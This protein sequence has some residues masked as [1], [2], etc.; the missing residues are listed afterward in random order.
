MDSLC[1][2]IRL[3]KGEI[4]GFTDSDCI[5]IK[6]WIHNAVSHFLANPSCKRIAGHIAIFYKNQVPTP[7]ELYNTL[8]SFPQKTHVQKSGTSVTGNLF[9]YKEVFDKVGLFDE[10]QLSLG[11][12]LWGRKAQRAGNTIH[13]VSD[14]RVKHPA[15]DFRQLVIKEKRVGGGKATREKGRKKVM[16]YLLDLLNGCR[17]RIA[18]VKFVFR[19]GKELDFV[20]KCTVLL[21]RHYLLNIRTLEQMRVNMGKEPNRA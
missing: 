9:V 12:L 16:P 8:Y 13:F 11:D 17:P 21:I 7:A 5:P 10:K 15:R 6:D 4:I 18:E 19:N 2:G 14:V 20:Q 1:A 3:A